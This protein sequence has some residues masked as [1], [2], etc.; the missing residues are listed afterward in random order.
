MTTY[1]LQTG[2]AH[3]L[4][5]GAQWLLA[6]TG[7]GST[8]HSQITA[9]TRHDGGTGRSDIQYLFSPAGFDLSEDGPVLFDRPAVT[10]LIN[11]LRPYSRGWVRLASADPFA[12]PAI[13]PNLFAD[14][15]DLALLLA[16]AKLQ[17]RIFETEP[18]ARFI[19]G[20]LRPGSEVQ[21]DDEWRAYLRE[22]GNERLPPG[23]AHARWATT[24]WQWSTTACKCAGS[25]T[26]TSRMP[27]S[28]RRSSAA[29][30]TRPASM[31][32]EKAADLVTRSGSI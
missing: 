12:Q 22:A 27:R 2:L 6:G 32:G 21:S 14:E 11:V 29:I 30:S 17:R 25:R 20:H 4:V 19:A 5:L 13:Q 7:P 16:G 28:C 3:A 31:I 10:G 15:R 26:S 1:N 18:L 9:F 24:R 8:P 23:G